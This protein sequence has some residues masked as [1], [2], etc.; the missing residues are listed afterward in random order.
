MLDS[1]AVNFLPSYVI[2]FFS[3]LY[4]EAVALSQQQAKNSHDAV[5]NFSHLSLI[6]PPPRIIC[7]NVSSL[8]KLPQAGLQ[9]RLQKVTFK[10]FVI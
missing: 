4:I 5:C 3:W 8:L 9:M 2:I 10:M 1:F 7:F 6:S